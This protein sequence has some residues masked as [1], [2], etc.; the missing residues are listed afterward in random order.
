MR[1]IA[2]KL[3]F[4]ESAF[5]QKSSIAAYRLR[6]F[7][8][9]QEVDFCGHATVAAF[10]S[11]VSNGHIDIS[12][13]PVT[14]TQETKAGVF[15]VSCQPDGKIMMAQSQPEFGYIERNR[16]LA[17]QLLGLNADDLV[18]LP[19]QVVSTASA[20]LIIAV[21]TLAAL[22]DIQPDLPAITKYSKKRKVWGV[23]AFTPDTPRDQLDFCARFFDPLV[24]ID[25]D[26]ATGVA[27]GPLAC[28]AEKYITKGSKQQFVISQGF[29]MG[30]NST[31][32][33]D[34]SN[35]V[36]VGGYAAL[37]GKRRLEL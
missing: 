37:Y 31:I 5:I 4:S 23:Y 33:T 8:S 6:F 34:V 21:K 11:L 9:R 28:Y 19:I 30:M 13:G 32:Y 29:D 25:E 36:V 35:K 20:K 10:H 1:S 16:K 2:A 15:P 26:A 27:A 12:Q 22:R 18:D 14:V 17:S 24:G 7:S 3:G